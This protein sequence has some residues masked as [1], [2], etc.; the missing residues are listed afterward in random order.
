MLLS[1]ASFCWGANALAQ[2]F[3]VQSQQPVQSQQA[4]QPRLQQVPIQQ[5]QLQQQ[6]MQVQPMQTPRFGIQG[7]TSVYQPNSSQPTTQPSAAQTSM[8]VNVGQQTNMGQHIRV[9]TSTPVQPIS[10]QPVP[11]YDPSGTNRTP[12][13]TPSPAQGTQGMAHM[14]RAEPANRIIPFFLNPAEQKELDEFLARWERY[15]AGINRYD[16]NFYLLMYNPTIPGAESNQPHKTAY[17]YF[18]YIA[19]PKRFVYEIEGEYQ[20]GKHIKRDG[21]N[22]PHIRAEKIIIDERAVHQY[23]FDAKKLRQIN[24]PSEMIGKGIADSPLPLIFGAKSDDLK[25]RFS[26]KLENVSDEMVRLYARPLLVED[27]HEFKELEVLIHKNNLTARALKQWDINDKAYK[28][29]DLRAPVVNPR[30]SFS[31]LDIIK[32]WFTPDIPRGWEREEMDYW[33]ATPPPAP[34]AQQPRVAN[35]PPNSEVPLYRVQ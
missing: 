16:V 8:G 27:Q 18:K 5:Q 7:N 29:F 12:Q 33:I 4:T 14:G 15:S 19:S 1:L 26:M 13:T 25:R 24:V 11:L 32:R 23:D 2:N 35:P 3:S 31:V 20:D 34:A 17:G 9:A 21:D 10:G 22:N 6:P 28:V 30:E